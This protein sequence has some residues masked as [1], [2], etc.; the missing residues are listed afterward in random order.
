MAPRIVLHVGA[1]KTGSTYL[2]RRLRNNAAALRTAGIYLPVDPPVAAMAG[3]A[4]LLA[5]VL[6]G[7]PSRSFRRAFPDIDVAT[8]QPAVLVDQ[9]LSDWRPDREVLVLSAENFRPGHAATLRQLL[10][11]DADI[12]VILLVRA[13]DRW[14][15]SYHNQL[16][17]T[18]DIDDDLP[19]F[20]ETICN[21]DSDR[22]CCPDWDLHRRA[23]RDAFGRC[24]TLIYDEVR[25]HLFEAFLAAARLTPPADLPDLARQQVSLDNHQLAYLLTARRPIDYADFVRRRAASEAASRQLPAAAP[26]SL[27]TADDRRRLIERFGTSNRALAASLNRGSDVEG[28][29]IE[30]SHVPSTSLEEIYGSAAYAAHRLL[31]DA[32]YDAT[33]SAS[34]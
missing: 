6:S 26:S 5:T 2:Q 20:I 18:A 24:Q 1:P 21:P 7:A 32:L 22:L 19:S 16:I 29:R 3:N 28:L 23:W 8:L 10:P 15:E 30:R 11:S 17:K 4:K 13:Q 14:V 9:F 34:S 33:A 25:S 27:L 12:E 31:A